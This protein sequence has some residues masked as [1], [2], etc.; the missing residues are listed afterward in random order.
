M[1]K[2]FFVFT[3]G[4]VFFSN[5]FSQTPVPTPPDL[6]E[7]VV[8]ITTTLIQMDAVVTDKKGK[9]VTDLTADDFEI[10]E[11]GKKQKITNFAY[12][13]FAPPSNNRA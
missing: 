11:N 4:L 3:L 5:A 13:T 1:T 12:V 10:F 6:E 7:E 9:Q 8:R 2:A